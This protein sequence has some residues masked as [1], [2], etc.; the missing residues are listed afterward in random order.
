MARESEILPALSQE[1]LN[2]L[3]AE[4]PLVPPP[5]QMPPEATTTSGAYTVGSV[6]DYV[7]NRGPH[8]D[9]QPRSRNGTVLPCGIQ[10][11][12]RCADAKRPVCEDFNER[13]RQV[14]LRAPALVVREAMQKLNI[15]TDALKMSRQDLHD[16]KQTIRDLLEKR[17]AAEQNL[18]SAKRTVESQ[19]QA[20]DEL[21]RTTCSQLHRI[22]VLRRWI[23]A[24]ILLLFLVGLYVVTPTR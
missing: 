23:F 16:A 17:A 8:A 18:G 7:G 9:G 21:V 11:T 12:A 19:K 14:L 2:K 5:R 1:E 10:C 3:V 13:Q 15:E 24:L 4:G 22:G 6:S 20:I